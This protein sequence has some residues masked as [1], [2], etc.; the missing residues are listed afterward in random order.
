MD[1]SLTRANVNTVR[2]SSTMRKCGWRFQKLAKLD[3]GIMFSLMQSTVTAL[4]R[5]L[6]LMCVKSTFERRRRLLTTSV[7][8][9]LKSSDARF[10]RPSPCWQTCK[11]SGRRSNVIDGIRKCATTIDC[12]RPCGRHQ[13]E[14]F[15]YHPIPRLNVVVGNSNAIDNLQR[16]SNVC[17]PVWK[18]TSVKASARMLH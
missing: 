6:V 2:T 7:G 8:T 18:H 5:T 15:W 14:C 9:L 12:G 4:A 17:E 10:F 13:F 16:R 3:F 1:F 11:C